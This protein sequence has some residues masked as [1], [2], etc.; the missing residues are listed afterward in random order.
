MN[1]EKNNTDAVY[2]IYLYLNEKKK[3]PQKE[4]M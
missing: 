4:L 1:T 2:N 3:M